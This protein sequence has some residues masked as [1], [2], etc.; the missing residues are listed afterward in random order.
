MGNRRSRSSKFCLFRLNPVKPVKQATLSWPYGAMLAMIF[1]G[2]L[3]TPAAAVVAPVVVTDAG[4]PE[5]LAQERAFQLSA[6]RKDSKTVEFNFKIAEGYY[7][8]RG[9]F[10]FAVEPT[11][12]AIVGMPT[13]TKGKMKQDP[14]FGRTVIY[15][16]SVRILLPVASL[17]KGVNLADA[18]PL[19]LMV[20]S[21]GCADA[22]VCYPPFHQTITLVPGSSQ[23]VFPDGA[24][25]EGSFTRT[26][27]TM[28]ERATPSL[29]DALT[30][31]K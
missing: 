12:N 5:L 23:V 18:E 15:R 13:L 22:G 3:V 24:P 14:T 28:P 1:L 27:P 9:K 25:R 20:T 6:R 10:K 2:A 11:T 17:H 26:L 29:I 8:Y 16:D 4:E 19:R 21:Q 31:S 30:K 7:M